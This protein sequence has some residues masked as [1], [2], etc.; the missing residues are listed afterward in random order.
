MNF[1]SLVMKVI[2]HPLQYFLFGFNHYL[3]NT[4]AD[5]AFYVFVIDCMMTF[6]LHDQIVVT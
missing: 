1:I 5:R 6:R 3:C 4:M 2:L